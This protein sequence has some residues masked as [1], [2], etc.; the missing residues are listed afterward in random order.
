M[1][2]PNED[3]ILF[4]MELNENFISDKSLQLVV[5]KFLYEKGDGYLQPIIREFYRKL[6]KRKRSELNIRF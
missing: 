4:K 3:D 1:L 5:K 2:S 6:P